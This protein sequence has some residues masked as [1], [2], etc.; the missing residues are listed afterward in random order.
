M[1]RLLSLLLLLPLLLLLLLLL[2]SLLLLLLPLII[3]I[4]M[5]IGPHLEVTA[6]GIDEG[7]VGVDVWMQTRLDCQLVH[8]ASPLQLL[9]V[10]A[11]HDQR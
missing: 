9:I 3:I 8:L 11:H 7:I 5:I 10:D 4:V 6:I 1:L 2:L